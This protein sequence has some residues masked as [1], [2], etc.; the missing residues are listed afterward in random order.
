[1]PDAQPLYLIKVLDHTHA[2]FRPIAFIQLTE[3]SARV[4]VAG[5]AILIL[6]MIRLGACFHL[7]GH[8]RPGFEAVVPSATRTRVLV[9]TIGPAK[10]A[11]HP[12]WGDE[13]GRYRDWLVHIVRPLKKVEFGS[14]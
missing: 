4:L 3:A 10:A 5:E 9:S 6:T 14:S 7:A 11:V 13:F 8:A 12:A 2:V 1:L